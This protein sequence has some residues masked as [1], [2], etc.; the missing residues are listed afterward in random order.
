MLRSV[1]ADQVMYAVRMIRRFGKVVRL[2]VTA[3]VLDDEAAKRGGLMPGLG[4]LVESV[5]IGS[6]AQRAGVQ[7]GDLL[8]QFG[9]VPLAHPRDLHRALVK[10]PVDGE[11]SV[12]ILRA[13]KKHI[14]PLRFEE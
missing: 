3:A 12:T 11:I 10:T 2:G 9:K 4:L 1:P 5:R 8:L 14:L 6:P 13:G 7:R